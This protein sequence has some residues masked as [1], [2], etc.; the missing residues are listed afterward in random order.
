[1]NI[2]SNGWISFAIPLPPASQQAKREKKDEFS[3]ACRQALRAFPIIIWGE[4][5]I[6]VEWSIHEQERYETDCT[7][8]VD[9]ILKPLLDALVGPDALLIDDSQVQE[10]CCNWIDSPIREQSVSVTIRYNPDD[11]FQRGKLRFVEFSRCLCMPTPAD[12]PPEAL[13]AMI[14]AWEKS[15]N[16]RDDLLAQ[17][18]DWY[19][20]QDVMP[21]LRPFHKSRV[22][23]NFPIVVLDQIRGELN[24][25]IIAVSDK[26]LGKTL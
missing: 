13:L 15:F 23:K 11:W 14:E 5:K 9:N 12:I 20:A 8:D 25:E 24:S 2:E 21:I 10:V 1:M 3:Q 7:P 22:V 6:H 4:A 16:L 17:G 19:L 18:V 26:C